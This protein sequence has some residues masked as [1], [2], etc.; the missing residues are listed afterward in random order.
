M[1]LLAVRLLLGAHT[2][3]TSGVDGTTACITSVLR[4]AAAPPGTE[5]KEKDREPC[6][7]LTNPSTMARRW[8]SP[9]TNTSCNT[10]SVLVRTMGRS[11]ELHGMVGQ[12][13]SSPSPHTMAVTSTAACYDTNYSKECETMFDRSKQS[14]ATL[15]LK[16]AKKYLRATNSGTGGA[17]LQGCLSAILRLA[18]RARRWDLARGIYKWEVMLLNSHTE[19]ITVCSPQNSNRWFNL[20]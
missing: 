10:D 14:T 4:S 16:H 12:L 1:V 6:G 9:T 3:T 13:R 18:A 17:G 19:P 20:P 8:E 2:H 15:L 11:D 5:R 7:I